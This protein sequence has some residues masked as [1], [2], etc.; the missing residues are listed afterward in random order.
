MNLHRLRV[1]L[2]SHPLPQGGGA[3]APSFFGNV[4]LSLPLLAGTAPSLPPFGGGA[5]L[6]KN[7]LHEIKKQG[8]AKPGQVKWWSPLLLL[9]GAAFSLSPFGVVLLSHYPPFVWCCFPS[10]CRWWC[11]FPTLFSGMQFNH[12]SKTKL[13]L[14]TIN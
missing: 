5:C 12:M 3:F 13:F 2:L 14:I 1:V 8:E 6:A 11:R 7:K 10:C 4:L 9:G